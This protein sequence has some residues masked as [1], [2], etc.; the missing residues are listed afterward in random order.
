MTYSTKAVQL[1]DDGEWD[2]REEY[3]ELGSEN[4]LLEVG[5]ELPEQATRNL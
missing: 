3:G 5:K 2:G 4:D 1:G